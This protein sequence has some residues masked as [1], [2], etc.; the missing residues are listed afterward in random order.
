MKLTTELTILGVR[1]K[2]V[3]LDLGKDGQDKAVHVYS[4]E[5]TFPVLG[6]EC[7]VNQTHER[8][9]NIEPVCDGP[10]EQSVR[11][12]VQE[13]TTGG[14]LTVAQCTGENAVDDGLEQQPC[15]IAQCRSP[16][17]LRSM[18]KDELDGA[19]FQCSISGGSDRTVEILQ[20]NPVHV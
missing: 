14:S 13:V 18:V 10:R 11:G 9:C 12:V 17:E 3:A 5:E 15:C 16:S 19:F 4:H 8:A 7:W 2:I 6:D 20:S 1:R